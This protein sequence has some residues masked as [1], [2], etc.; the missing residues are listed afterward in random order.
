MAENIQIN[1]HPA[2]DNF[3][4]PRPSEALSEEGKAKRFSRM[5]KESRIYYREL[6]VTSQIKKYIDDQRRKESLMQ[7]VEVGFRAKKPKAQGR[8]PDEE[9]GE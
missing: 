6:K 8:D 3:G 2:Q 5:E 9:L 7:D 1:E 4:G